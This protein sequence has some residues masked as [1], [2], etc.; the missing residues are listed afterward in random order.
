[1]SDCIRFILGFSRQSHAGLIDF[2]TIRQQSL[3]ERFRVF[4]VVSGKGRCLKI[5]FLRGL[6]PSREISVLLHDLH[7]RFLVDEPKM[8]GADVGKGLTSTASEIIGRFGEY[9]K[10]RGE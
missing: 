5:Y 3:T 8:S 6:A 9:F 10:R 1:M 7:A 4:R 2:E